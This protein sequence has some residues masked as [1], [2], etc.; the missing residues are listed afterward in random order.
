MNMKKAMMVW[1][2]S[3]RTNSTVCVGA[4]ETDNAEGRFQELLENA[5]KALVQMHG[6][7][8]CIF[9]EELPNCLEIGEEWLRIGT[10]F[11]TEGLVPDDYQQWI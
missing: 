9:R 5:P 2:E 1:G 7:V 8:M 11:I 10:I 6:I 3:P 4:I